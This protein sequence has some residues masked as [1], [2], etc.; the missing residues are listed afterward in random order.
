MLPKVF[1]TGFVRSR[2]PFILKPIFLLPLWSLKHFSTAKEPSIS[3]KIFSVSFLFF[4]LAKSLDLKSYMH[5][6]VFECEDFLVACYVLMT[7]PKANQT[8]SFTWCSDLQVTANQIILHIFQEQSRG[9]H[10]R[11]AT[12][13]HRR[14]FSDFSSGYRCLADHY[15]PQPTRHWQTTMFCSTPSIINDCLHLKFDEKFIDMMATAITG[16]C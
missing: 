14:P 7:G 5:V 13:N 15:L 12:V 8:P 10:T 2:M 3:V 16:K 11:L 1:V 9:L 6:V 4:S